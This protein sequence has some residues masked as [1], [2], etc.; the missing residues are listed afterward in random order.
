MKSLENVFLRI[1][2]DWPAGV[3]DEKHNVI[4]FALPLNS[5]S[6]AGAVVFARVFQEILQ[7]E[8]GI[9]A[10]ARDVERGRNMRL[11]LQAEGVGNGVLIVEPFFDQAGQIN[12][13]KLNL[14]VSGIHAGEEEKIVNDAG[15]TIGLVMKRGKLVIHPGLEI[16]TAQ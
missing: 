12:R 9:A 3:A 2:R 16:L 13:I 11:D 15:K 4:R 1:R 14:Q 5:H 8:R 6:T 10:L 7:N